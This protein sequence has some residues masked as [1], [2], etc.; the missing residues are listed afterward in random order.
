MSRS[1][2]EVPSSRATTKH[3]EVHFLKTITRLIYTT[4]ILSVLNLPIT[5]IAHKPEES[6]GMNHA[7][8][9]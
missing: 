5:T 2:R 1:H 9:R 4:N 8:T 7:A 3:T 6:R